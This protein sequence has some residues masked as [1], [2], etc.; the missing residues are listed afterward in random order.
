MKLH[1]HSKYQQ[2]SLRAN[3]SYFLFDNRVIALGS[4]IENTDKR[5]TTETT[6]FQFAVPKLQSVIINGKEVNQLGTQLTLNNADTLIDPA[7]NLYKLA[8]GQTVE[9]SYQKQH[10]VDDR[11]S[12]PTEQLFATAVISHGKAPNNA[13]YEYAIAIESQDNKTPEYTVLQHNNQLHAVK[14]KITQ[15]EGYAFFEAAHLKSPQAILLSSDAPTMVMAKT[16]NQ[17]LTLSIVNPDLN[18][19]QGIEAD[20][21]DNN[22]NQVEVSVYSRQWLT[23]DSKPISSTVTVKGVWKLATPQ[24]DVIIKHQNEN[25]LITTTTI[26]ATPIV[27]SLVK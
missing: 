12:Q 14:D 26:Q 10:S 19:Y 13:S 11:N 8:K 1:G 22:G 4:G 17:Q 25:T 5:H 9:F 7:G 3:K 18:L 15:E 24:S 20:Q 2:Q 23:A 27:I 16:Q 6:L 21:I